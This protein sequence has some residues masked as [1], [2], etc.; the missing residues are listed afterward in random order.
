[1]L[2]LDLI[3]EDCVKIA[4]L[5]QDFST[6]LI[7]KITQIIFG[8][9]FCLF[10]YFSLLICTMY[11][12][13]VSMY[14]ELHKK[15]FPKSDIFYVDVMKSSPLRPDQTLRRGRVRDRQNQWSGFY[16]LVFAG[17]TAL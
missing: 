2:V 11:Q 6:Y 5:T 16:T 10:I 1:M 4:Y 17:Q 15:A 8:Y 7:I 14:M 3:K 13:Y 9:A 12:G